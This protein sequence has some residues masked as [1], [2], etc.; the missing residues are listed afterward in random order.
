LSEDPHIEVFDGAFVSLMQQTN[1]RSASTNKRE[2]SGDKWVVKSSHVS[3][4][5]R[6]KADDRLREPNLFVRAIAVGG[7]VLKGNS[8]V[9]GSLEDSITWNNE[10]IL[11]AET[12]SFE[13]QGD[14][15]FIRAKR[16]EHSSLVQDPSKENHGVNVELPSGVSLI[17]NR[18]P[19][20]VNV[21]IS[22]T[23][24]E[25]GQDGLCGNFNGFAADDALSLASQRFEVNVA[26][27]ESLFKG[28]MFE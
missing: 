12:S 1:H 18:L 11:A 28:F 10:T 22:M 14:G 4:Q 6:Y 5:A 16:G 17:V 9:I 7:D 20:H 2:D 8:I 21:A 15:F 13:E 26:S 19:H 25:G 27:E 23:P 24:Q 3:I